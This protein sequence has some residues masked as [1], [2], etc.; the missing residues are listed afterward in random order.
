MT[1]KARGRLKTRVRIPLADLRRVA[2]LDARPRAERLQLHADRVAIRS[3]TLTASP[4]YPSVI[5]TAITSSPSCAL[6]RR[7]CS[8]PSRISALRL[9]TSHGDSGR[10]YVEDKRPRAPWRAKGPSRRIAVGVRPALPKAGAYRREGRGRQRL[11]VSASNWGEALTLRKALR[12]EQGRSGEARRVEG[13]A[14]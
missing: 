10:S 4:R 5:T 11:H 1:T 8:M 14:K 2:H 7:A 9:W 12:E 13:D 6:A 3:R